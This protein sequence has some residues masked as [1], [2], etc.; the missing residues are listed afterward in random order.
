MTSAEHTA[1]EEDPM[2][3]QQEFESK[4]E[5]LRETVRDLAGDALD[6]RDWEGDESGGES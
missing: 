5:E 2:G 1:T 4:F 3:V 6:I